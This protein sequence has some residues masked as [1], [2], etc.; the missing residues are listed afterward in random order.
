MRQ[1]APT[2]RARVRL[3]SS[4]C[5][6][7]SIH[8]LDLLYAYVYCKQL[9]NGEWGSSSHDA[10]DVAHC[11]LQLSTVLM[12]PAAAAGSMSVSSDAASA[13][14]AAT[15]VGCFLCARGRVCVLPVVV[16]IAGE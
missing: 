12:D 9:Y 2:G 3:S 14:Q 7:R 11:A 6:S 15:A 4:L 10:T 5:L 1:Q 13:E 8:M 16:W